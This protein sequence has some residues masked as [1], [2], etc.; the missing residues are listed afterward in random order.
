M[1]IALLKLASLVSLAA[2]CLTTGCGGSASTKM[3]TSEL[4]AAF[5]NAEASLKSQ[6]DAAAKSLNAGKLMDGTSALARAA[7]EAHESLSEAQKTALLGI[8][9]QV[10]TI[11]AEDPDRMDL[12][13][14]QA[15]ENLIA[16]MEGRE[17][18]RVGMTPDMVQPPQPAAE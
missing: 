4:V 12:N 13:I 1:K 18:T 3:D 16:G 6:V 14:Y 15:A 7:K 11:M 8:V 9:T 10:Q 2:F 17:A 5:A